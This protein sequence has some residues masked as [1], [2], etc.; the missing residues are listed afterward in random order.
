MNA[1]KYHHGDLKRALLDAAEEL[2]EE[3]GLQGFTLR[4]C[5]RRAGVSHAAPKHHYGDARGLLSAV[6]ERGFGRLADALAAAIH[7]VKGDLVAEIQAT[8]QS[9]VGFAENHPE[10]FRIMFRDDLICID[11]EHPPEPVARTFMELTNVILRQRGEP[12]LKFSPYDPDR[13]DAVINDIILG[14]C[15]IHGYAHLRL[16][17][18]L[19][20]IP[21]DTHLA[22]MN[23]AAERL[24][25]L[26]SAGH[27]AE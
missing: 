1:S 18:Q 15:Y 25:N 26:L 16:E 19:T 8:C 7:P 10:H 12:E 23:L 5:A 22:Q 13:S 24:S 11:R 9:Y 3:V 14:W 6:A 27:N 20:M 17:G 2:L 21:E 4:A